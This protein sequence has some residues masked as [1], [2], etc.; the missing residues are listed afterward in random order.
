MAYARGFSTSHTSKGG[1]VLY[2]AG[3]AII[4]VLLILFIGLLLRFT[5]SV[6]KVYVAMGMGYLRQ[7]QSPPTSYSSSSWPTTVAETEIDQYPE[8]EVIDEDLW[9]DLGIGPEIEVTGII[10][11]ADYANDWSERRLT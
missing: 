8:E 3:W 7:I 2:T 6:A 11:I 5:W 10:Q 1:T 4:W 9:E